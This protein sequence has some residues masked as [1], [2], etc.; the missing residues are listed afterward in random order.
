MNNVL[1]DQQYPTKLK[2]NKINSSDIE[3]PILDF[4]FNI[5]NFPFLDDDFP[6]RT[7]PGVPI[8]QYL[9]RDMTK[10]TK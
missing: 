6:R 2:L 9:S 4:N 3:A 8:S 10:P 7:S 5:V 1:N